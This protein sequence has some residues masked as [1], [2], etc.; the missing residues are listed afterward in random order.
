MNANKILLVEDDEM[1]LRIV[2]TAL[3]REGFNVDVSK[4][5]KDALA[6]LEASGF[7]YDLLIT[8]I[9]LPFMTGFELIDKVRSNSAGQKMAVIVVSSLNNEDSILQGFHLGAD[10]Y[11][12]KPIIASEL[13]IRVK[14]LLFP[15]K[16]IEV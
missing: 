16:R 12:K 2:K 3:S 14:K 5:G 11:V 8:D 13:I 1:M 9:M 6:Q 10:D 4:N 15:K 7:G